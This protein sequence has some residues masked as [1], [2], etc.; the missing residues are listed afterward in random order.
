VPNGPICN[1]ADMMADP[2]FNARG[3]FE[4]VQVG[5]KP[6][7]IPAIPP[8]L[9]E[10]PGRT[11]APGPALGEHTDPVLESLLGLSASARD[12]LRAAGAI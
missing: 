1:V 7:R 2:H 4:R 3:M 11:D 6:L 8:I 9:G 5:G 12:E 10:T